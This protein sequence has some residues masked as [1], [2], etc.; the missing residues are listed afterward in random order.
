MLHYPEGDVKRKNA[1]VE[2]FWK[3]CEIYGKIAD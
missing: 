1:G 2:N 3:C